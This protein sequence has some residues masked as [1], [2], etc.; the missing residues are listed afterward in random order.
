LSYFTSA[1]SL[2]NDKK[3]IS[4]NLALAGTIEIIAYLAAMSMSLNMQR[5]VFIKNLLIYSGIVHVLFYFVRPIY[6]YNTFGRLIIMSADILIRVSMSMGNVFM[7]VYT[8][9]TFPTAVR[10]F[11]LGLLGFATKCMYVVSIR[12]IDFWA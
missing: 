11:A 12:F 1:N 8:I 9:E 10:H 5:L 6:D 2:L 7:L 4:F 3:S